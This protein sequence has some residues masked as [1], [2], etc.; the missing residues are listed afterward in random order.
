MGFGQ[1][2]DA[3][4][5]HWW[6]RNE[7]VGIVDLSVN[8]DVVSG[9][10][11]SVASCG[12]VGTLQRCALPASIVVTHDVGAYKHQINVASHS[13]DTITLIYMESGASPN[14]EIMSADPFAFINSPLTDRLRREYAPSVYVKVVVHLRGFLTGARRPLAGVSQNKAWRLVAQIGDDEVVAL[15]EESFARAIG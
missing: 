3:P 7:D 15:T 2:A 11:R 6:I 12:V 9:P 14:N 5:M 13:A 10:W 8:L 1:D 4:D